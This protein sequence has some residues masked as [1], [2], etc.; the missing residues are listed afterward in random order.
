ML[1][2]MMLAF[3]AAGLLSACAPGPVAMPA[4]QASEMLELFAAGNPPGDVCTPQGRALLRGAV[5]SY[6]NA[7]AQAGETWPNFEA[8]GREPNSITSVEASVVIGVASGFVEAS[9]LRGPARAFAM[10]M[11]LANWPSVRDL[12]QAAVV[13]CPEL[14]Q[15][16]QAAS[17]FVV[18]RER[19]EQMAERARGHD[20]RGTEHLRRLADRMQR[21]MTN[22]QVL[23]ETVTQK[24]EQSRRES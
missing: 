3:A 20:T 9:D 14:V 19:Y 11:T 15:L 2:K 13:A 21:S 16:Q 18:E 7:M 23:A 12:R 8:F 5:R 10:H 17:R 24:V 6:G 4:T 22:M 1:R